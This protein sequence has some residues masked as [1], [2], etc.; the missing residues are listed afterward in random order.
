MDSEGGNTKKGVDKLSF[1]ENLARLQAEHGETN[2]R[3]AKEIDVSQT[4]IKN[5][6]E[7]VCRPHPRQVKKLA[8]HYGVTVDAL[9]KSSD[10][11]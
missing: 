3:L 7:S 4:S 11:Q 6:K 1:A 2:Y 8:K 10:G 5:W 9:L